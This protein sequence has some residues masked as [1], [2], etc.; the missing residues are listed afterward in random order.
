LDNINKNWLDDSI[1]TFIRPFFNIICMESSK[2]ITYR[3][4]F[5]LVVVLLVAFVFFWGFQ[6]NENSSGVVNRMEKFTVDQTLIKLLLHPGQ[7]VSKILRVKNI[8]GNDLDFSFEVSGNIND[9]VSFSESDGFVL[10]SGASK[11]IDLNIA[12]AS[13]QRPGVY[14]G[15]IVVDSDESIE[16]PVIIE[17]ESDYVFFDTNLNAKLLDTL[18]PGDEIDFSVKIFDMQMGANP[19]SVRMEYTLLDMSGN[20][21]LTET[22]SVVV[23]SQTEFNKVIT[24]PSTIDHGLYVFTA[25]S[26]YGQSIGVSTYLVQVSQY[27]VIGGD[28]NAISVC[29]NN[30]FC[31]FGI[32][33]VFLI[34]MVTVVLLYTISMLRPQSDRRIYREKVIIKEGR[35]VEERRSTIGPSLSKSL[36]FPI[37]KLPR[38]NVPKVKV[39]KFK[40]PKIKKPKVK[41]PKFKLPKVKKLKIKLP[42]FK[43][44]KVKKLKIKLPKFRLPKIKL[45]KF[46][47]PKIKKPKIKV[48]KFKLP[49]IK[50]LKIKLPKFKLPKVKVP[51]MKMPKPLKQKRNKMVVDDVVEDKPRFDVPKFKAPKMPKMKLPKVKVP[52]FKLPKIKKPKVKVPK[53]KLPKVKVP[54]FKLP[55]VKKP[56]IKLPKFK[57]PK[58]KKPKMPKIKTPKVKLPKLNVGK[59]VGRVR[60]KIEDLLKL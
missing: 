25:K 42:K 17:V 40:L 29:M 9:L 21:I 3:A 11:K 41:L 56:K 43:L 53:F 15:K 49:K 13:N 50:K 10:N 34:I 54:K 58:V 7:E 39:P 37:M 1:E 5:I 22:E 55:K 35:R 59:R 12:A 52:K 26:V 60:K 6:S 18:N 16:I 8:W 45:P 38:F 24:L 57:L 27:G 33:S 23:S 20:E 44:P 19:T 4:M 28:V 31:L 51:K 32:F 36:K 14:V 46:K 30:S 48:P 2:G 47:L